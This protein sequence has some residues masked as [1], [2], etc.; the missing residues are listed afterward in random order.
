M[1][2]C[3]NIVGNKYGRLTV[4]G[5]TNKRDATGSVVWKCKCNCGNI[6]YCNVTVLKNG[7]TKSCG[8]YKLDYNREQGKILFTKHGL[9]NTR[10]YNTWCSMKQRCMD[11]HCKSYSRYGGRGIKVC[12][13][14]LNDF[15]NF[16]KWATENGYQDNLTID[17][18]N[19][20]G[21]YEP[22]NCR[23]ATP[24][25]QSNNKRNNHFVIYKGCKMT[26]KQLSEKYNINYGTILSRIN[27]GWSIDDSVEHPIR[28]S[29][30]NEN[31]N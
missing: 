22:N 5:K 24:S 9:K 25:E 10:L 8:C 3:I 28:K 20:N 30:K 16:Y 13:E 29:G 27:R 7:H 12:D 23:W 21:N 2:K 18:I 19:V 26:V 31:N 6:I 1:G 15:V 11:K 4:I 17:R 14:W